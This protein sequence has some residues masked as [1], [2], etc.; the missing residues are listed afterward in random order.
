MFSFPDFE[1]MTKNMKFDVSSIESKLNEPYFTEFKAI[2]VEAIER[3]IEAIKNHET[4]GIERD[5]FSHTDNMAEEFIRSHYCKLAD[6][7]ENDAV[8]Q[9]LDALRHSFSCYAFNGLH[10]LYTRQENHC[11]HPKIR[12]TE[13]LKPN[14]ISSLSPLVKLYRGCDI[15]EFENGLYGQAWTTSLKVAKDFAHTH[16]QSQDWFNASN[17]VVLVTTCSRKNILFSNQSVEFEV[18]VVVNSLKNIRRYT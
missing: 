9:V 8:L 12:L 4:S 14:D 15:S 3:F 2:A 5:L 6:R 11:W 18:V 7:I 10:Q 13:V 1:F 17:R 16:Y